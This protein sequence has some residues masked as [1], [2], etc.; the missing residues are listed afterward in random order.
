MKTQ[1]VGFP[2]SPPPKSPPA[3]PLHLVKKKGGAVRVADGGR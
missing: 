1:I 3:L 2:N